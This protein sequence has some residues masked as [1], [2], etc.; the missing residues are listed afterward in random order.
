MTSTTLVSTRPTS[1]ERLAVLI[2]HAGT[3]FAWFLAPLLVYLLKR[4]DSRYVEFHALQSL[5]WSLAGTVIALAT[6]GLAIPVFL[7][8]HIIA[9]VKTADGGEYE[10]P[11]VGEIARGL[12]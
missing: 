12:L 6:W 8:W 9:A 7:V 3:V 11:L 10:Y 1:S 4:G 2:A 5:L